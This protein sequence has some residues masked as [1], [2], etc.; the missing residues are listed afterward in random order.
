MTLYANVN[1][2]S[3]Y[4]GQAQ[5]LPF[6]VS[7]MD[8]TDEFC[9]SGNANKYRTS[10]LDFYT[11]SAAGKFLP[12][13]LL[14]SDFPLLHRCADILSEFVE[15]ELKSES[16]ADLTN[17]YR[18]NDSPQIQLMRKIIAALPTSR[19]LCKQCKRNSEY[20]ECE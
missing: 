19:P 1:K 15:E 5:E 14:A 18:L 10:D 20:C 12:H 9:W 17:L 4:A 3:K 8:V 7:L 11:K 16:L 6:E 13:G 2:L